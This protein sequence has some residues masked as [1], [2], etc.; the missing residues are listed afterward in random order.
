[1]YLEWSQ[2][3]PKVWRIRFQHTPAGHR[4]DKQRAMPKGP[5]D[6]KAI[7]K[8]IRDGRLFSAALVDLA[9]PDDL[10]DHF[11]DLPPIFKHAEIG[12]EELSDIMRC[13]FPNMRP[14]RSLIS[15]YHAREILIVTPQLQWYME[16]GLLVTKVYMNLE[17]KPQRCF[18]FLMHSMAKSRRQ[19]DK[20]RNLKVMG[21]AS[22]PLAYTEYGKC[23]QNKAKQLTTRL[24]RGSS[25]SFMMNRS[26]YRGHKRHDQDN[27]SVCCVS[28]RRQAESSL[29]QLELTQ[30]GA[31]PTGTPDYQAQEDALFVDNEAIYELTTTPCQIRENLPLQ[32]TLFVYQYAKLHLL[33]FCFEFMEAFLDKRKWQQLYMDT[34]SMYLAMSVDRLEETCLPHK[35]RAFF[36]QQDRWLP[37]EC[38]N[39]QKEL[40]VTTMVELEMVASTY[41]ENGAK[42]TAILGWVPRREFCQ[43]QHDHD[44]REPGLFKWEFQGRSMVSLCSK[45]YFC[46][47]EDD[48]SGDTN[49]SCKGIQKS[50]K[51][52]TFDHYLK[53][54]RGDNSDAVQLIRGIRVNP[55]TSAVETYA[56]QRTGLTS[57][58]CKRK[59]REDGVTTDPLDL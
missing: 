1:M 31:A 49:N 51:R 47:P 9:T 53:L 41:R 59:V 6:E 40:Y 29:S 16:Q 15:S 45:T 35:R 43:R 4:D 30:D 26:R 33:R 48:K 54:L 52:L 20:D 34:D 3:G 44:Q 17:W 58:Y 46:Q 55:R 32:I 21:D 19:T 8:C 37:S 27:C 42:A 13:R 39:D 23:I 5:L 57:L 56:Q 18:D 2:E 7:L 22:K 24:C 25:I 12:V 50:I 10:K 36:E 14:Q 28:G 38:C 11:H